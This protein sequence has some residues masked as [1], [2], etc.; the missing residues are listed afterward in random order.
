MAGGDHG[1]VDVGQHH[2]ALSAGNPG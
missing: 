1:G 2:L